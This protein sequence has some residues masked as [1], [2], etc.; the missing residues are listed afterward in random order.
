MFMVEELKWSSMLLS[1]GCLD[2]LQYLKE[3][4]TAQFKDLSK[5]K[6]RRTGKP[7]SP[8]TLSSRL[9][10]LEEMGAISIVAVKTDR[11]RSLGYEIT[12][13]GRQIIFATIK[14]EESLKAIVG[15]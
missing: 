12:E 11:K 3:N 7:F 15:R 1:E 8:N 10:D 5:L 14:F 4:R 13:K 9:D 6:N 2:I